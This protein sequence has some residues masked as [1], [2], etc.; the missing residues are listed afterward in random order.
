[1]PISIPHKCIFVHIP[2]T[3]GTSMEYALGMHGNEKTIGI[4]KR[5]NRDLIQDCIF[6]QGQQHK[7]IEEIA[8]CRPEI[9]NF[10]KFSFVRNPWDK[11]VSAVLFSG[12]ESQIEENISKNDFKKLSQRNFHDPSHFTPQHKFIYSHGKLAVDFVG[13][14]E[15]LNK[16][17]SKVC[18][19]LSINKQLEHRMKVYGKKH[20]TEYYDNEMIDFI[21]K[22]YQKDIELFN[23]KFG[24]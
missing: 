8:K 24:D 19:K 11:F 17:F 21:A 4:K 1:M 7:A 5:S 14:F 15:N 23:Y 10:F 18:E 3:G 22:E 16:D 20:Y 13:R 2:K 6:G 12:P 9:M